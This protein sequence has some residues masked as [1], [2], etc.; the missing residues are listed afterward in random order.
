MR[1]LYFDCFA[2]AS[3]NMIL[4]ALIA[5]GVD[6]D[7]L[8]VELAKLD[9]PDFDLE[10]EKVDRSGISAMHVNVAV[11]DEAK[12]RHLDKIESLIKN[13]TISESAKERSIEIFRRLAAAEAKVHGIDISKVHFHEVGGL[14]AII[15]IVGACIGFELL[16]I[17]RFI[18]S[19]IHVG[20]GFVEMEHGKF[21]VPPPA[22]AELLSGIP[23]Y[24]TE[25]LGELITPTGA[26][27]ISTLC[28]TYGVLPDM[29]VEVVS[30]GAGTRKYEK[31]PNVLRLLIG[32][33]ADSAID[34]SSD[35][36]QLVLLETNIDDSTPQVLGFVMER[37]LDLGA[38]DFWFTPI[39]MKKSRPA[40][41]L[42]VLCEEKLKETIFELLYSETTTLGIRVRRVDRDVLERESVSVN[43]RFGSID[44]KIGRRG[45]R[46]VNVMPE[47]DQVKAAAV[48]HKVSFDEVRDAAIRAMDS[49]ALVARK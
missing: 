29:A 43:T 4:G 34:R 47:Y 12:H 21:P 40:T 35:N 15:D 18:C 7:G 49:A 46:I 42:S 32:E 2:G 13:S 30:Y 6:A 1:T 45:D 5:A 22:V 17:E 14:D 3:G 24:S 41:M 11:P 48:T 39:Q 27:L 33:T 9:L 23:I 10:V 31:F 28:E 36:N 38:N 20:S 19:K 16:G 8:T 37:A 25:V 44:V 26:A